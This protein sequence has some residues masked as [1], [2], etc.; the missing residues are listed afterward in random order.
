MKDDS[1]FA[2]PIA[3]IPSSWVWGQIGDIA[4]YVSRGRAPNYTDQTGLPV[5]NQKCIRWT[6]IV[7]DFIKFTDPARAKKLPSG[8]FLHDGDLL[9]NSTGTGT[10]GR[11]AIFEGLAGHKRVVV[12]THVTIVRPVA[13]EPN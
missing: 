13:Y 5:I 4:T 9:W 8:Q 12:D 6:G 2:C 10:I 7:P 11:A 3:D 1:S